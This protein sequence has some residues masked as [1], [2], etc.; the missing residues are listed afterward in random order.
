[1]QP[2]CSE[3]HLFVNAACLNSRPQVPVLSNVV[4][5]LTMWRNCDVTNHVTALHAGG[6]DIEMC[7]KTVKY[8]TPLHFPVGELLDHMPNLQC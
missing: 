1:M 3:P 5:F 4:V 6:V 7:V 2:D 8:V